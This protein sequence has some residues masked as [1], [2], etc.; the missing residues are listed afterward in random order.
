MATP[1][2]DICIEIGHIWSNVDDD[3]I[4]VKI[5]VEIW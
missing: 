3:D 2:I 1:A 5:H 4:N